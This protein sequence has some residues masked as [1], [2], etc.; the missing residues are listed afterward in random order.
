[1]KISELER[2]VPVPNNKKFNPL[3]YK[4]VERMEVGH[5]FTVTLEEGEKLNEKGLSMSINRAFSGKKYKTQK[6]SDKQI[7]IWRVK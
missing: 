7:R 1:M 5:S 2:G 4:Q 3:I 6:V